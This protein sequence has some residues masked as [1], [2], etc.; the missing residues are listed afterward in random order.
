LSILPHVTDEDDSPAEIAA[1]LDGSAPVHLSETSRTSV[2]P[3][4]K[5]SIVQSYILVSSLFSETSWTSCRF[6]ETILQSSAAIRSYISANK[7]MASGSLNNYT[8][9]ETAVAE[10]VRVRQQ[11]EPSMPYPY[12][13]NK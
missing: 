11:T 2:A 3:S 10:Q 6:L 12:N 1:K 7:T 4:Y 9:Q 13:K 5:I 8:N